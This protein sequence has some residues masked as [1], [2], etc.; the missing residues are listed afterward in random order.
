MVA[1]PKQVF[2]CNEC[3]ELC[4]DIFEE[5]GEVQVATE[6]GPA[7][8]VAVTRALSAHRQRKIQ[9]HDD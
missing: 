1:G 6:A 5:Q 4:N 9:R 3:V 2:I 7:H 8:S